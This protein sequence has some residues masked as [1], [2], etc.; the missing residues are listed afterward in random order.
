M[1]VNSIK[2]QWVQRL[3]NDSTS[4][5]NHYYSV[6]QILD[7]VFEE[8]LDTNSSYL[9][10]DSWTS[11]NHG[12]PN[13]NSQ[14]TYAFYAYEDDELNIPYFVSSESG[15]DYLI[16]KLKRNGQTEQQILKKSGIESG[17]LSHTI[18]ESD[19][20]LLTISYTKDGSVDKNSDN[21]GVNRFSI[22]RPIFDRL[23]NL[24]DGEQE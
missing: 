7:Y 8:L 19:S 12:L 14:I 17:T 5:A 15:N 23:R 3:R 11:T 4:L 24:A 20:Y 13:S 22:Y 2:D 6:K 21:A 9:Y 10:F 16:I 1:Y 18:T